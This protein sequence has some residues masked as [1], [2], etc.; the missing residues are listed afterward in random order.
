[1]TPTASRHSLASSTPRRPARPSPTPMDFKLVASST[2]VTRKE[3]WVCRPSRHRTCSQSQP[4]QVHVLRQMQLPFLTRH[5]TLA[6]VLHRS[7]SPCDI[8]TTA[9]RRFFL[10]ASPRQTP[11]K[12]QK[13]ALYGSVLLLWECS[14][15]RRK[16]AWHSSGAQDTCARG[17]A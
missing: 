8:K 10:E 15:V 13:V 14:E 1:M 17:P 11:N 9:A 4:S 16:A 3:S 12:N 5:W 2:P 7:H 6:I